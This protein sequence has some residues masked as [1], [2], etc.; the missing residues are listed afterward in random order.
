MVGGIV[1][2]RMGDSFG[3]GF[4]VGSLGSYLGSLGN[5]RNA[6]ELIGNTAR[7]AIV[8]GTI[9]VA[10]GGKF[11]NG[12]Q[13]G[14][15]G[16]Y[17]MK[18]CMNA[19]SGRII[20]KIE[21]KSETG[22]TI[23]K[24]LRESDRTYSFR[25]SKDRQTSGAFVDGVY[26]IVINTDNLSSCEVPTK[27]GGWHIEGAMRSVS[28]EAGHATLMVDRYTSHWAKNN[29][30]YFNK[31]TAIENEIAREMNPDAWQHIGHGYRPRQR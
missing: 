6:N 22:V 28:H 27:D 17:L 30:V 1:Q 23:F 3:A 12:A 13:T 8:G 14:C 19:R 2:D 4:L 5:A 21:K 24:A 9:S 11:A 29:S 16:I 31:A 25:F 7:E 18:L 15:L 26:D 20:Q 10:G